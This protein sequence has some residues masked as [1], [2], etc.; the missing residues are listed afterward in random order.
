MQSTIN[1][2]KRKSRSL[3]EILARAAS[4]DNISINVLQNSELIQEFLKK[5]GFKV[6]KSRTKKKKETLSFYQNALKN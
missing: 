1:F 6:P 4:T 2:P 3:G 5:K